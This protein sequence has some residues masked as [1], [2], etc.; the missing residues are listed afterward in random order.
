MQSLET[1][2]RLIVIGQDILIAAIFLFGIGSKGVRVTGAL[3]MLSTIGYLAASDDVLWDAVG[4]L[5]PLLA[6]PAMSVPYFLWLFARS[7]F[8][9]PWPRAIFVAI[10]AAVVVAVWGIYLAGS[11][12]SPELLGRALVVLRIFSLIVVAHALWMTITGRSGD[13]IEKRRK[14]RLFFVGIISVQVFAVVVVELILGDTPPPAWLDMANVIIIAALTLI[15]AIPLLRLSPSFFRPSLPADA[16]VPTDHDDDLGAAGKVYCQKL[17]DL[18]SDGYYRE[19]G[20]TIPLLA[21]KLAYPE[22]QLRR[23]I[24]GHLGYRN[25]TAFLNSYR[26]AE[27]KER[28]ADP[29]QARTPVLTIALNLGYGS[30]GPFNRAFKADTSMTPTDYRRSALN[31]ADSE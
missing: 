31:N 28:L 16:P 6:L 29:E 17:L 3:L 5:A 7:V 22:H 14:F 30:L 21:G 19:T 4:V 20:L 2:L 9:A 23:L 11:A 15:L 18:M 26:I 27:A 25:F 24:N 13:L 10:P 8:E 12:V 1:G